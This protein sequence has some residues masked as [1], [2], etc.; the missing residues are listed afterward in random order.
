[1]GVRP[2]YKGILSWGVGYLKGFHVFFTGPYS[3]TA[4]RGRN[5][6]GERKNAGVSVQTA[7]GWAF[8]VFSA[9]PGPWGNPDRWKTSRS[10]PVPGRD[11]GAW[12]PYTIRTLCLTGSLDP[13]LY[14]P[15]LCSLFPLGLPPPSVHPV[16]LGAGFTP[17]LLGDRGLAAVLAEALLLSLSTFFLGAETLLLPVLWGL[18]PLAVV[19]E[20]FLALGF[21]LGWREFSPQLRLFVLRHGF[22]WGFTG[23]AAPFRLP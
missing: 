23:R 22:P 12:V 2:L 18:V 15:L 4:R 13:F 10:A 14:S 8:P 6:A 20:P 17:G 5:Y 21:D 1:M 7:Q 19:L 16:I 3:H 11:D 9:P